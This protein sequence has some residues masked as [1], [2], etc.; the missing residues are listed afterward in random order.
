[1]ENT[2]NLADQNI[3][4][5]FETLARGLM[6]RKEEKTKIPPRIAARIRCGLK[7]L[8]LVKKENASR[9]LQGSLAVCQ[10]VSVKARET[11]SFILHHFQSQKQG[12]L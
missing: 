12:K 3:P 11:K 2:S 4:S 5:V 8:A 1:M 9:W 10:I 7:C 6:L